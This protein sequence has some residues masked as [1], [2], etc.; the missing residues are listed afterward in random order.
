MKSAINFQPLN[1]RGQI[2]QYAEGRLIIF[3]KKGKLYH[4]LDLLHNALNLWGP[5]YQ[6]SSNII[7]VHVFLHFGEAIYSNFDQKHLL[8]N[9]YW[10]LSDLTS[11]L[12]LSL[13][14]ES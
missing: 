13:V 12:V 14:G 7:A 6:Y 5:C 11:F 10:H 4:S 1:N 8:R 9:N 2:N 3:L